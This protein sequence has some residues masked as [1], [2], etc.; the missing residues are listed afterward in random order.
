MT[1]QERALNNPDLYS[2]KTNSKRINSLLP[3]M[4]SNHIVEGSPNRQT[5]TEGDRAEKM[6]EL[7]NNSYKLGLNWRP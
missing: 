4:V 1:E 2:F 7:T 6:K 3:G 5:H